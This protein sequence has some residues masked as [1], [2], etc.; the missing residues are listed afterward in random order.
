MFNIC[1]I[2][3]EYGPK[4]SSGGALKCYHRRRRVLH[5]M[6]VVDLIVH[7]LPE[8]LWEVCNSVINQLLNQR[9]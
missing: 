9:N 3:L 1:Y 4:F 7:M 8:T 5:V 6:K 2:F